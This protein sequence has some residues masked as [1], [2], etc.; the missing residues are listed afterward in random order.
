MSIVPAVLASIGA[1]LSMISNVPQAWKVRKMHTTDD[2]HSY[3]ILIHVIAA[4]LW[5]VY[6]FMLH[7]YI[8][9]GESLVVCLLW[10][11]IGLAIV[12][13]RY[14]FP[15]NHGAELPLYEK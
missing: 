10:V 4:C 5:S 7:L 1:F 15:K 3:S 13:D 12:R 11:L 9:G 6:G 2:L 8:L 14:L